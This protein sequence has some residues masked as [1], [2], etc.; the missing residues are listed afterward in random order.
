[1]T[2]NKLQSLIT[3]AVALDRDIQR[4]FDELKDIKQQLITVAGMREEEHTETEGGGRSWQASGDDGCIARVHFPAP[5][6]KSKIDGEGKGIA[7]IKEVAGRFFDSLFRPAITYRPVEQFRNI[8]EINLGKDAKKLVK[9]C[10]SESS[11]RVSFE[12]KE[13]AAS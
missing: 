5:S 3:R 2:Q 9:L 8:A 4:Q 1:M 12:T 7:K 11:P 6:L 13:G 10:E